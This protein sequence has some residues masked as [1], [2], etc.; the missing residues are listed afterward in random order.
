MEIEIESKRN[1]PLLNRIEVNFI[2]KHPGEGTPNRE[3]IRSELAEKLNVKK[4]NIVVNTVQSGFGTQEVSG[5]AKVYSSLQK[6][7]DLEQNYILARNNIIEVEKKV[8]K[9]VKPVP[10]GEGAPTPL[11]K[12]KPEEPSKPQAEDLKDVVPKPTT[13]V[14][15]PVEQP[16]EPE[17]PAEGQKEDTSIEPTDETTS[18]SGPTKDEA[19]APKPAANETSET[20]EKEPPKEETAGPEE[21]KSVEELKV[22]EKSDKGKESE[23]TKEEKKEE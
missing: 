8:K 11:S 7:R 6:T 15:P 19:S 21:G 17:T 18:E 14:E 5:Y 20:P 1:N 4:E 10:G 13:E 16:S 2:V 9:E 3:I 23:K 22:E 12:E